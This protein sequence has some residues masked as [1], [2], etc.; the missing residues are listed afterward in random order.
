MIDIATER[1]LQIHTAYSR[2]VLPARTSINGR[3][4]LANI[5]MATYQGRLLIKFA[6]GY[7]ILLGLWTGLADIRLHH[8]QFRPCAHNRCL[9]TAESQRQIRPQD[10][11]YSPAS[12]QT[13]DICPVIG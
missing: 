9:R 5:L 13:H 2:S 8:R 4:L 11:L 3:F 10:E 1:L 12:S 6:F 7:R